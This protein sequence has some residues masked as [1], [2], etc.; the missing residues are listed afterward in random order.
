MTEVERLGDELIEAI[1]N[2]KEC[3]QYQSILAQVKAQPQLYARIGEYHRRSL[4]LQFSDCENMIYENN[5]LQKEFVDL[6]NNSLAN[7]YLA[8]EHQYCE[9]IRNFQDKFL[10]AVNIDI[11]FLEA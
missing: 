4:A 2:S 8:A 11:E 7:E 10:E 3:N 5:Q 1:K 6:Q 9:L